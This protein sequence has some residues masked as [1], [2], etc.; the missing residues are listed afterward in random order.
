MTEQQTLKP[1]IINRAK[2]RL[3]KRRVK[4][5][6]LAYVTS[7]TAIAETRW[8]TLVDFGGEISN[9]EYLRLGK[10]PPTE[11]ALA[12]SNPDGLTVVWVS[13]CEAISITPRKIAR[14]CLK[15]NEGYP[16]LDLFD[17]RVKREERK[18]KAWEALRALHSASWS[19]MEQLAAA[20][21]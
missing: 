8:E 17:R 11:V 7:A 13:T 18:E 12:V 16:V 3:Q 19:P 21:D 20:A 4:V 15:A 6:D 14:A 2:D 10:A 9:E 1:K 5:Q